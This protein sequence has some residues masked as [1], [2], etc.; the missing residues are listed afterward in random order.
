[1]RMRS[2]EAHRVKEKMMLVRGEKEGDE[3]VREKMS[4][5]VIQNL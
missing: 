5:K 2:E 1:M 3:M 4:K